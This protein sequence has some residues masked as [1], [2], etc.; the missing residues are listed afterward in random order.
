[1]SMN[2]AKIEFELRGGLLRNCNITYTLQFG[3]P[4]YAKEIYSVS[5]C[6]NLRN[7]GRDTVFRKPDVLL[8]ED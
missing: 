1:M 2:V 8:Q 6:R 7:E 4:F 5:F 3:R